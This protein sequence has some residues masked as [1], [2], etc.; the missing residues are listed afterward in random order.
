MNEAD[1]AAENKLSYTMCRGMHFTIQS[2]NYS[3][4][5]SAARGGRTLFK[6][7]VRPDY[8]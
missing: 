5:I 8:K 1:I 3:E 6:T 7:A 4:V 2:A